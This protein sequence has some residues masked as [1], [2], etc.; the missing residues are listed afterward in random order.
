MK[1]LIVGTAMN[2]G[3]D[4]I[5]NFIMS[6]RKY[7]KDDDII[8][9]YN[10]ND[11]SRIEKFAKEYNIQL[12]GFEPFDKVPIHVVASRFLKYH[13]ILKENQNYKHILLADI[14]D[15]FFQGNPFENLPEDDYIFAFTE[16]PAVTIEKEKYHISM[17]SRLF[18]EP[19]LQKFAGKK[20]ICSGTILGTNDRLREWL[21]YFAHY[22]AQIQNKQPHI[23]H[24]MLLDQVIA[25]HIF[26]LQE[27]KLA[28]E[29]K[30][31][32]DIVGTIGHC[33]THPDHSGDMQLIG[34][35][36]YLDGKVPAV[37]HQYD[38]SPELFNFISEK[39][40]YVN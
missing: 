28:T 4:H 26:Y 10:M 36:I 37:I 32:G 19:E 25:N 8:L 33:I 40:T 22:L 17:I 38:R 11:V 39:Y 12:T 30:D 34:D 1:N 6:F 21:V 9:V 31:N 23:C 7:N 2:Y 35:T 5:K 27:K 15:V 13:D 16:D 3:V 20:I 14:R 24:E 18:G 29:I